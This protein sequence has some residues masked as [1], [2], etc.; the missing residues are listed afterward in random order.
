M[1]K[2][3]SVSINQKIKKFNKTINIPSDKSCSIRALLFASVCIGKSEIVN[4]LE[5]EDVLNCVQALK[6]LGVKIIKKKGIYQVYGNGLASYRTGKKT[7]IWVGNSGTLCRILFGL[8]ATQPGKFYLYGDRSL[9]KRDMSRVITPLEKLGAFFYPEG[10]KTLPLTVEGTSMPLAQN[11]IENLGSAQVKSSLLAAFLNTPGCS[12]IEEKKVSRNHTEIF[13]KKIAANIKVKKLNK[14]NLISITGQQNLLSFNNYTV[15]SDPSSAAFP[16]A[17][18]LLTKGSKLTIHKVICNDTRIGFIKILKKMNANV[19]IMNLKRSPSSGELLGSIVACSS[20]LKGITVSKDVAK[21][22][23]EI[24]IIAI[25][26]SLAKGVTKFKNVGELKHKESDRLI[27]V[28]KILN[29]A[30]VKCKV[31]KNSMIIY[32]R[33][34]IN[35]QNKSILVKNLNDHRLCL[36][37]AIYSLATGIKTKIKN[38][39]NINTSFPNFIPLINKL[40]GKIIEIK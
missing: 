21:F 11:H 33:D 27:E 18:A 39:E 4:L 1:K 20:N 8:L 28:K 10:K 16:I 9:N 38:F 40:G 29:Q 35:I 12:T 2:K 34:K 22:I 30:G 26:A 23:D 31:T 32:G 5:S 13:L 3:F 6:V 19:K 37:S 24:P 17:L 36:S 25:C 14:G 15:G 7:K